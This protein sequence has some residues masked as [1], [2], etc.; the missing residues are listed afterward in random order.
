MKECRVKSDRSLLARKV[1]TIRKGIARDRE[2]AVEEPVTRAGVWPWAVPRLWFRD[3]VLPA[4]GVW[5]SS[6]A[7]AD[8]GPSWT[9]RRQTEATGYRCK[10]CPSL[11]LVH[12]LFQRLLVD[13]S[14]LWRRGAD[15]GDGRSRTETTEVSHKKDKCGCRYSPQPL[16]F[17]ELS[18]GR[19][20]IT[21]HS[22]AVWFV[23]AKIRSTIQPKPVLEENV[24]YI[25]L[26]KLYLLRII[27]YVNQSYPSKICNVVNSH[28]KIRT[29]H[30]GP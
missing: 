1:S 16:I 5:V 8:Q 7:D 29:N 13:Q 27:F 4:E 23:T 18:K 20:L 3:V 17:Y 15:D 21:V 19:F 28:N 25:N 11:S 22:S 2:C 10:G 6:S 14:P 26:Y 30:C 9:R 24:K 12:S